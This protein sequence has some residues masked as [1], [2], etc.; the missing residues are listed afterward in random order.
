MKA[1][2][3]FIILLPFLVTSCG[4][5]GSGNDTTPQDDSGPFEP[6]TSSSPEPAPEPVSEPEPE[7]TAENPDLPTG[8]PAGT[9][10][11]G[12][13]IPALQPVSA[14]TPDSELLSVGGFDST[15]PD[16]DPLLSSSN[17]NSSTV[18]GD[19][20]VTMLSDR[21]LPEES[22]ADSISPQTWWY[23]TQGYT[24]T[25]DWSGPAC[26]AEDFRFVPQL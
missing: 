4:G 1:T 25:F 17:L 19:L 24:V 5:S 16:W 20:M 22:S 21:G 18:C 3:I 15:S 7:P 2:R 13:T 8:L 9:T 10:E 23:W 6:V 12:S 14:S 11:A 26:E